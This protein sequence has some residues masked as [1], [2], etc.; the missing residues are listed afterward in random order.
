MSI[1]RCD[2]KRQNR[3]K[4]KTREEVRARISIIASRARIREELRDAY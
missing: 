3:A 2:D 4:D 1:Y